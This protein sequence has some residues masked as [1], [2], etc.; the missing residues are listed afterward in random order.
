MSW[1]AALRHATDWLQYLFF[2]WG[3]IARLEGALA[4]AA[5]LDEAIGAEVA[6]MADKFLALHARIAEQESLHAALHAEVEEYRRAASISLISA[7]VCCDN[8]LVIPNE[9]LSLVAQSP[10]LAIE[11]DQTDAGL[12]M[13]VVH[14]P[15]VADELLRAARHP[16]GQDPDSQDS[17]DAQ[18]AQDA[19][20]V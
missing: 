6:S 1:T 5:R 7:V 9:V 20:D 14:L 17:Q 16:V 15:G 4:E 19:G 13:Q 12:R 10:N 3:R 11:Y 18:D 2:P 8:R